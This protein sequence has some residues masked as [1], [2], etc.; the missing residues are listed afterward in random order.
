MCCGHCHIVIWTH[1][2]C[3]NMDTCMH[4]AVC[5]LHKHRQTLPYRYLA[6]TKHNKIFI[7]IAHKLQCSFLH[8]C[9]YSFFLSFFPSP[10]RPSSS[11]R[12]LC[13]IWYVFNCYWMLIA[14]FCR[15]VSFRIHFFYVF[16]FFS[17]LV[18]IV[19]VVATSFHFFPECTHK[20][21][22]KQWESTWKYWILF[23]ARG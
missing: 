2:G 1:T 7:S 21:N 11:I 18:D 13:V 15:Y 20:W 22:N 12:I 16:Q 4:R 3:S 23:S 6:F 19:V 10:F 14:E 9:C 5:T 8:V 17:V